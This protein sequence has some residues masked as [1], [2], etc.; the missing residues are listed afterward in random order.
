MTITIKDYRGFKLL[1]KDETTIADISGT[2]MSITGGTVSIGGTAVLSTTST[3]PVS[4]VSTS[5]IGAAISVAAN[6]TGTIPVSFLSTST[7]G[8]AVTLPTTSTVNFPA[9]STVQISTTSTIQIATTATI[10]VVF[11]ATS[12]IGA[13]IAWA[14]GSTVNVSWATTSTVQAVTTITVG[15]ASSALWTDT[16]IA[17]A[18]TVSGESADL[19]T[20]RDIGAFAWTTAA[21]DITIEVAHDAAT[22]AW[23]PDSVASLSANGSAAWELFGVGRFYRFK[24]GAAGTITAIIS[25]KG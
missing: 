22:S 8:A 21:Q 4:F 18:G 19:S 10:P 17:G 15:Y 2:L 5:T 6:Q 16:N 1:G 3:I 20:Y 14:A 25:A 9:S 23:Y 11:A 24:A 12:T 7:I 13:A